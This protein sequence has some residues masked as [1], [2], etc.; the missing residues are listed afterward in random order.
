MLPRIGTE[1]LVERR[2]YTRG[3]DLYELF[4]LRAVMRARESLDAD[5]LVDSGIVELRPSI[6]RIAMY[7]IAVAQAVPDAPQHLVDCAAR[8]RRACGQFRREMKS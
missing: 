5:D 4:R 6:T 8:R 3:A 1:N 7:V 2:A